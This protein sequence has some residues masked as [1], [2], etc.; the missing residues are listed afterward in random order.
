[1]MVHFVR[2]NMF[3]FF[4]PIIYKNFFFFR[5]HTL[6]RGNSNR[7]P[8]RTRHQVANGKWGTVVPD[9]CRARIAFWVKRAHFHVCYPT[10]GN[11]DP[12]ERLSGERRP[13]DDQE[14]S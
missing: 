12:L 5:S 1:M 2:A 13:I 3:F 4:F 14:A 7:L 6:G 10:T 8:D 11:I 9:L